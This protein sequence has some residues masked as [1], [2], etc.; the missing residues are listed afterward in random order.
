MALKFGALLPSDADVRAA[1]AHV[2]AEIGHAFLIE[3]VISGR[4]ARFRMDD[5]RQ[6]GSDQAPYSEVF[7]SNDGSTIVADTYQ[8]PE[9]SQLRVVFFLHYLNPS[10]PLRTSYG[11][12]RLPRASPMPA[13]L[14]KLIPY[15]PVD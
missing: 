11:D 12:V 3:A 7:L 4:D 9:G 14:A 10:A 15:E 1:E 2:R 13:R 5:F 6:P 8:V